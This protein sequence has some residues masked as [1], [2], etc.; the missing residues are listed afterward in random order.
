M[1]LLPGIRYAWSKTD[2]QVAD[3]AD[4]AVRDADRDAKRFFTEYMN[5]FSEYTLATYGYPSLADIEKRFLEVVA[6]RAYYD[7][8]RFSVSSYISALS[9]HRTT[10][11][12]ELEQVVDRIYKLESAYETHKPVYHRLVS[13]R[14]ALVEERALLDYFYPKFADH[15]AYFELYAFESKLYGIYD[16]EMQLWY[17]YYNDPYALEHYLLDTI[18]A[19]S[20]EREY[21][22]VV[23]YYRLNNNIDTLRDL[24]NKL[25]YTYPVRSVDARK[26]LD[27]L[28][29]IRKTLVKTPEYKEQVR[30]KKEADDRQEW[31]ELQRRNTRAQEEAARA[32]ALRAQAEMQRVVAE[33]HRNYIEHVKLAQ[34]P[35]ISVVIEDHRY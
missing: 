30:L 35:H 2:E 20:A 17:H 23:Y 6:Y 5:V 29:Y 19:Y 1:H 11:H 26:L 3:A 24:I 4:R 16:R 8:N 34:Q 7:L 32:Q 28:I 27:Y 33:N 9:T 22:L 14:K 31:L 10:L 25:S 21:P 12:Q 18:T 15:R 13:L